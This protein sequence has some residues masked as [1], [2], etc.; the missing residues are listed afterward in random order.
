MNQQQNPAIFQPGFP[1]PTGQSFQLGRYLHY[2]YLFVLGAGLAIAGA[3]LY[4][5]YTKP[6]YSISA[7]VL[8]KD[9]RDQTGMPRNERFDYA[10]EESVAKNLDNEII[11]LKSVSLMQRVLTELSLNTT[12]Y[13]RGKVREQEILASALPFKLIAARLDSTTLD[14]V[15]TITPQ[16]GG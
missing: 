10:N 13:V 6:L 2:W 9:K 3:V 11:L 12:Y 15:L 8:I 14:R 16:A 7:S 4:L 1:E 5:R